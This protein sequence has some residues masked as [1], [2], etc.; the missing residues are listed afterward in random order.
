MR[1]PGEEVVLGERPAARTGAPAASAGF[2]PIFTE[3]GPTDAPTYCVSV[4]HAEVV[5]GAR[6]QTNPEGFDALDAAF[7]EGPGMG[8]YVQRV[9][10]DGAAAASKVL[11]DEEGKTVMTIDAISVGE[12]G[13]NLKAKVVKEGAEFRI[14]VETVAGKVLESSPLKADTPGLLAWAEADAINIT[15]VAGESVKAPK[16]QTVQLAGGKA[17]LGAADALA[18][19]AALDLYVKDFGPGQVA[20]PNFA[21]DEAAQLA[22]MVH[23]GLRNR[24]ALL[25]DEITADA[26]ELIADATALSAAEGHGP[27]FACLFGSWAIIPGQIGSTTRTVP[28][29]GV[30]MGLIARAEAE[31]NNPNKPAAGRKRGKTRWAL[32]LVTT[33]TEEERAELDEAG[34]TCAI[35]ANGVPTTFGDRTL[36]N[37]ETDPDWRSFAASRTVMWVSE[38]TRQVLQGFEFEDIDGHGYIFKELEGEIG[39]RACKPLYDQGALY[40]ET[41]QE[42]FAVNT[43]PEVNT[44]ASIE[45]DEIKA[46]VAIRTS[47][48]GGFLSAEVV[49]VPISESVV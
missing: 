30:A 36:V 12:W 35:L 17:E 18:L 32:G 22:V 45:A 6:L 38:L 24:R 26:D 37:E 48:N 31:G 34:V 20:A 43:G 16:V 3:K 9:V 19:S 5:Y 25:D 1:A 14:I 41:P 21:G 15:A 33:F 44:P 46:Q 39:A 10:G 7:H 4:A 49:K 8:V 28:Y 29:S 42:A 47:P 27:R 23:C 11:V 2:L 13:N 40:G